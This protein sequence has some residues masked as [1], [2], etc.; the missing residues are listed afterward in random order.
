V[1][2]I[3]ANNPQINGNKIIPKFI[4]KVIEIYDKDYIENSEG[5]IKGS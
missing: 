5:K 4:E 2:L 1:D 3:E